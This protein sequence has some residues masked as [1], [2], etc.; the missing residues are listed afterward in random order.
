MKIIVL[1][2]LLFF[3]T[4]A[5]GQISP[6]SKEITQK[7][8]PEI[9]TLSTTTPGLKKEKGFT[10]YKELIAF[11]ED[12]VAQYPSKISLK[13]IGESQ[14]GLKIPMV[15]LKSESATAPI[16]VWMQ[17]GLHGDEPASTE[18]L[19]YLMNA[20]LK[21]SKFN[22]LFDKVELAIVPMANI[23][24]YLKLQ[25]NSANGL[26][27]NRDQTKLMAVETIAL[28]KALNDFNPQVA[29]DFHEYRPYRRDFTKFG[30]FGVSG[31]YDVMFLYSGNLNVPE[32]IRTFTQEYFVNNAKKSL[33]NYQFKHNDYFTTNTYNGAIHFDQGSISPRSSATSF[34][35]QN[36]IST[37]IEV[38]GV[39]INKTSFK[40]RIF[41]TYSIGLS[42][43]ETA[44]TEIDKV[45]TEISKAN[46]GKS[47]VVVKSKKAIYKDTLDFID[48]DSNNLIPL[49]V[50]L[51]DAWKSEPVLTRKRPIGY[52]IEA[53]QSELV[54]KLKTLGYQVKTLDESTTYTI[55]SYKIIK[56]AIDAEKY[57]KMNLQDVETFVTQEDKFFPTGAFYIDMNQNGSSLITELLEPEL[58]SSFVSFGVLKTGINEILP[59]YRHIH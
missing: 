19:L 41:I 57:E 34:A 35:L 54:E 56:Y 55:E 3:C 43:L 6:Q 45:K 52:I 9:D 20:L 13:Y 48:L 39:G 46:S 26:D 37:L 49:E 44:Y 47:D 59:I 2:S 23:D 51:R 30:N 38:R 31:S 4:L 7:F 22:Y 1:Y 42:Y 12:L 36:R 25:R 32:N 27:L 33:D 21:D 10:N 15:T 29:L 16:K 28:K 11:L 8:F 40:R 50:T 58:P 14:K 53:S 18:G 5:I 17:G 24:G